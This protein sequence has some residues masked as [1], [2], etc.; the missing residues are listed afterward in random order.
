MKWLAAHTGY[1]MRWGA[2]SGVKPG[3]ILRPTA[4]V[5]PI[6]ENFMRH[7]PIFLDLRGREALVVGGTPAATA[8]LR[9]L[10]ESG[11]RITLLLPPALAHDERIEAVLV[12]APGMASTKVVCRAFR[13]SDL[14]GKALVFAATGNIALDRQIAEAAMS[15]GLPVSSPDQPEISSFIMPAIVDRD[16]VVVAIST[17]GAAPIL[18]Q[19]LRARIEHLL[20][21]RLGHL[22]DFARLFRPIVRYK[23]REFRARRRFWEALFDG[24]IAESVL[25]GNDAEARRKTIA[26][27]AR[28]EATRRAAGGLHLLAVDSLAPELVTLRALHQIERADILIAD[29]VVPSEVL[30]HARREAEHLR[31]DAETPD[32][33]TIQRI[34]CRLHSGDK[35]V[36]ITSMPLARLAERLASANSAL[37]D[38]VMV[39]LPSMCPVTTATQPAASSLV[40]ANRR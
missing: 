26:A 28:P 25:A 40:L 37:L 20:P 19:R 24:P 38:F 2:G 13:S 9:L 31:L 6:K 1:T 21:I 14:D 36:W 4:E 10:G 30:A 39:V 29:P 7:F 17:G 18:A 35:I 11:V 3:S 32:S 34:L 23:I 12:H 33:A 15:R 22:A 8:K 5:S 27:L 16:P